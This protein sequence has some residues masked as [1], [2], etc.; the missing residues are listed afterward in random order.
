[1][2][3]TVVAV[4][5]ATSS[6]QAVSRADGH[7]RLENVPADSTAVEIR[8][9]GYAQLSQQVQQ[10][11]ATLD[12][13]LRP[14]VL[15]GQLVNKTTGKPVQNATIIA[16]TALPGTD[17]AF[18]QIENSSDGSFTLEGVPESGYL[19]VLAPGFSKAVLKL[20]PGAVPAKIEL[21]RFQVKAL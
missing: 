1:A 5:G 15:K 20:E 17:V 7:Y 13:V 14:D 18:S 3:A 19:Q 8:A 6:P 9:A 16:T 12:A 4:S 10:G 2:G 11:T 21:E